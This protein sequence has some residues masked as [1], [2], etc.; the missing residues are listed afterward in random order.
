MVNASYS[1][2]LKGWNSWDEEAGMHRIIP[3]RNNGTFYNV[4][5]SAAKSKT[6]ENNSGKNGSITMVQR[7]IF[8]LKMNQSTKTI[9]AVDGSSVRKRFLHRE[10]SKC[11]VGF[12]IAD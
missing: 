8:I 2:E 6:I 12:L 7:Q 1:F 3:S 11:K 5:I 10:W 9:H 4:A